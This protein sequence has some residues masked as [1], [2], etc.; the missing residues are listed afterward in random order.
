LDSL[1]KKNTLASA[2]HYESYIGYKYKLNTEYTDAG[3][4]RLS[5]G[6]LCKQKDARMMRRKIIEWVE[7]QK[8]Y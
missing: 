2:G 7:E 1:L 5:L 8:S 6:F 3:D 4:I